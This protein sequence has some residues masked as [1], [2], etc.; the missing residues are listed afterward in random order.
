MGGGDKAKSTKHLHGAHLGAG[1][2][3]GGQ[4][5]A[6]SIMGGVVTATISVAAVI[7][8]LAPQ[9]GLQIPGPP[10]MCNTQ[11]SM[12]VFTALWSVWALPV[13]CRVWSPGAPALSFAS[14]P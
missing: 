6:V 5:A 2:S 14:N 11:V 7:T 3:S 1:L 10:A 4:G 9:L 13:Q 12:C 8:S